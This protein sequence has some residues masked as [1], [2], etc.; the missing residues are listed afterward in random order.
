MGASGAAESG[1]AASHLAESEDHECGRLHGIE[2]YANVESTHVTRFGRVVFCVALD[3]ER[4]GSAGSE[5][6]AFAPA[7]IQKCA[8][9]AFDACPKVRRVRF[10]DDP[11]RA[12]L[13]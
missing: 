7:D 6:H 5:E 12:Q 13:D 10:E 3:E 11:L 2:A 9:V 8:H 1:A 4:F